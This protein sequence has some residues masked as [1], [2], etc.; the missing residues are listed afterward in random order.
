MSVGLV[1]YSFTDT[2]SEETSKNLSENGSITGIIDT[3]MIS[4]PKDRRNDG[5]A[6]NIDYSKIIMSRYELFNA[7]SAVGSNVWQKWMKCNFANHF[8]Y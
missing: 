1:C 4:A 8:F 6:V 3:N 5:R 7:C 2:I